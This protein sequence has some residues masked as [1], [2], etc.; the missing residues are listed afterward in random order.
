MSNQEAPDCN[1]DAGGIRIS[2]VQSAQLSHDFRSALNIVAGFS[3]LLVDE[4]PGKINE[5]QRRCLNDILNSSHRLSDLVN[6][7]FDRTSV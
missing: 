7:V 4:V 1:T 3:Q 6:K 5:D 2:S